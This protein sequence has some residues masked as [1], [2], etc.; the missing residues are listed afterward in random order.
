MEFIQD[1]FLCEN[2]QNKDFKRVY[3]FSL[4]FHHCNFSDELIYDKLLPKTNPTKNKDIPELYNRGKFDEITQYIVD[5]AKDFT[6]S[7]QNL[8]KEMPS[9]KELLIP[10]KE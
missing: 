8:K 2:C 10:R 3:N 9:L 4:R 7:F 1:Y 5:E 6:D